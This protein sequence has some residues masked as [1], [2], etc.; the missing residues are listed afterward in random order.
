MTGLF[1]Q[2]FLALLRPESLLFL[3]KGLLVTLELA[4]LSGGLSVVIGIAVGVARYSGV[5]GLAALA[6]LYVDT[7]RNL[8]LL[9]LIFFSKYGL[10]ALGLK[11]E[12]FTA[13]V[14][15]L[16][17]FTA[18]VVAEIV[19]GGLN[20]VDRGQWEAARSQ[21]F[22][23][24]QTLRHVIL[25]QALRK[26]IPALVQQVIT[27]TKDTSYVYIINVKEL[28]S[29][30]VILFNLHQNPMQTMISIALLFFAIN[31]GLSLLARRLEARLA[32]AG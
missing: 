15:A 4:A 31:F 1:F 2:G 13:G 22:T 14:T 26:M 10:G 18:A 21:G 25:P 28:T 23:Y 30:G 32:A 5:R 8:P 7:I 20:A 6:G 11:L 27:L 12:A 29:V 3:G 19:R 9:L 24:V 17:V 16:T